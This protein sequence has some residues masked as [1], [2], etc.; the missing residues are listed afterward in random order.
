MSALPTAH[1]VKT[2]VWNP[3]NVFV[4]RMIELAAR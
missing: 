2:F 4:T 3:I 1:N